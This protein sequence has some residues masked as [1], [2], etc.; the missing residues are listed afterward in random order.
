MKILWVKTDFLHPVTK[1]GQIRTLETLRR[2][3]ARHEVV[4][5][6]FENHPESEGVMRSHE[7]SSRAYAIPHSVPGR[8]SLRFGLQLARGLADPLPV[9]QRRYV[10]PQMRAKIAELT[11]E[12]RFDSIVCDF[13]APAPNM[14]DLSQCVLFQHNVETA[15][16]RRHASTA[17]NPAA[18]AYFQMQAER[19]FAY[20]REV[21]RKVRHVIAVSPEDARQ[22]QEQFDL[23]EPVSAVPTGVDADYFAVPREN[24]PARSGIVFVGSMDWLPNIDGVRYFV[25]SILPLIRREQPG[26]RLVIAGR[27]PDPAIQQLA[28]SSQDIVITGRVPDIRPYLWGSAVSVVPL[29]I[30]GGT[31]LKIYESMAAGVPV[32]S[33]TVGAEGLAV[34]SPDNIRLADTPETFARAC[35]ELLRDAQ[36]NRRQAEAARQL[37][38]TQ[39]G[40]DGVAARFE[41][42]LTEHALPS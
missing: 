36:Q 32:V 41:R 3:N 23:R 35:I 4:Y 24:P 19:M 15:I 9:S 42:I 12:T 34:Q 30:G 37:V 25:E 20:E 38:E 13:L 11:R 6:A 27:D 5:V 33:T 17:G 10:S 18:R 29:R 8:M 22:F 1:G 31:R 28:A 26:C 16:W 2:L 21:C 14:P 7:Y 40:W 39:F